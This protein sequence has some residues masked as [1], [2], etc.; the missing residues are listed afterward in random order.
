MRIPTGAPHRRIRSVIRLKATQYTLERPDGN[1]GALGEARSTDSNPTANLWLFAPGE[2]PLDTDFGERLTGSLQ[3]LALQGED[4]Q[5]GDRLTWNGDK[6]RVEEHVEV[7][8]Q[9]YV[10]LGLERAT[11]D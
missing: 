5:E 8:D 6:Y 3:G 10:R 1:I 9:E 7:E 4:V 2:L 11:N